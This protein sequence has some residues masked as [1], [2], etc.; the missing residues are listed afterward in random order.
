MAEDQPVRTEYDKNMDAALAQVK[1]LQSRLEVIEELNV[2]LVAEN[3]RL[4]DLVWDLRKTHEYG[5]PVEINDTNTT[6]EI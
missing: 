2:G 4:D 5:A 6:G 3:L 1:L